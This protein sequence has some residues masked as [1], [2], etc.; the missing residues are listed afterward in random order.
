MMVL[1]RALAFTSAVPR[2]LGDELVARAAD[3]LEVDGLA[4]IV[5]DLAPEARDLY[6]HGAF[7]VGER[8]LGEVG[9]GD[10][11]ARPRGERRQERRLGRGQPD[12]RAVA[13]E[14]APARVEAAGPE[15]DRR[16]RC[17]GRGAA[18]DGVD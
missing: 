1:A 14:L 13:G 15:G 3:G 11:L 4:R 17:G 16:G 5:L 8:A 6:V 9:A 12:D 7:L 2:E 10:H 18:Q